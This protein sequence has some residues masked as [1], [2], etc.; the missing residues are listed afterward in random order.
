MRYKNLNAE[1]SRRGMS[2]EDLA[3]ALRDRNV[4]KASYATILRACSGKGELTFGVCGAIA[5]ILGCSMEY[6]FEE[7]DE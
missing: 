7:D 2:K 6:L 1:L 4:K 3:N 5:E